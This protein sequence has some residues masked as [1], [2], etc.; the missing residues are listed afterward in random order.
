VAALSSHR[1]HRRPKPGAT[2]VESAM[3]RRGRQLRHRPGG[4]SQGRRQ[5]D[6]LVA[7]SGHPRHREDPADATRAALV[8]VASSILIGAVSTSVWAATGSIPRGV[9]AGSSPASTSAKPTDEP[10]YPLAVVGGAKAPAAVAVLTSRALA[11]HP[12]EIPDV[13]LEAYQRAETVINHADPSCRLEWELLAAWG[14][15]ASDHGRQQPPEGAPRARS[16]GSTV[17]AR[18]KTRV[19]GV[20]LL[21]EDTDEGRLDHD[22]RADRPVGPMQLTP[23]IWLVVGVDADGDARRDPQDI[24]DAALATA[25]ILCGG[26]EDLATSKDERSALMRLADSRPLV[27]AVMRLAERYRNLATDWQLTPTAG[28]GEIKRPDLFDARS[29]PDRGPDDGSRGPRGNDPQEPT[30][31]PN[32]P[33]SVPPIPSPSSLS[34]TTFS[35]PTSSSAPTPSSPETASANLPSLSEEP[36][37]NDSPTVAASSPHR[38]HSRR[39]RPR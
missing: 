20:Q 16:R 32:N 31:S 5:R 19:G 23:S 4:A 30:K 39:S 8:V 33:T 37:A 17:G 15:L 36:P 22:A 21:A 12:P 38:I 28:P 9:S 18:L 27:E 10:S 24:N 34:P 11:S 3:H 14:G 1:R 25:I 2:T 26:E 29:G 7:L 6:A 13:A 35:P